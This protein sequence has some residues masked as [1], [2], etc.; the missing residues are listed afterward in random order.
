LTSF[1]RVK[2]ELQV[3]SIDREAGTTAWQ[4]AV[5]AEQIEK[6]RKVSSPVNATSVAN[7]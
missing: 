5:A 7:D 1:A 3:I 6:V 2:A 4:V